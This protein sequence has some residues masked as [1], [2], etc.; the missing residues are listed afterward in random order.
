MV[1]E[2]MFDQSAVTANADVELAKQG[3]EVKKMPTRGGG[4]DT[5]LLAP[6]EKN[7]QPTETGTGGIQR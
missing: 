5:G 2:R 1:I 7:P 6:R 3:E 4:R